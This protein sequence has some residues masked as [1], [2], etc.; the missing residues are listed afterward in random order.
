MDNSINMD[1]LNKEKKFD[2]RS[3]RIIRGQMLKIIRTKKGWTQ[4]EAASHFGV[5]K[6]QYNQVENGKNDMS[7]RNL[8]RGLSAAGFG[9]LS[10][11]L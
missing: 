3:R 8:D 2:N 10:I 6:T 4:E 7:V 1:D 9:V 11:T 5:G